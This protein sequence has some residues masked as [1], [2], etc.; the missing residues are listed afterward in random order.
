MFTEDDMQAIREMHRRII[1][2]DG[3]NIEIGDDDIDVILGLKGEEYKYE[4]LEAFEEIEEIIS[5]I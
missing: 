4:L 2:Y 3:V 1:K 5:K